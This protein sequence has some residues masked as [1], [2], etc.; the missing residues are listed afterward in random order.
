[1]LWIVCWYNPFVWLMRK[2]V[3]QNIEFLTDQQVL[4]RGV[5]RQTYQYSLLNVTQQGTVVGIGNQFNFKTLKKRIMM[6]NK[7]RSSKL[8]LSKYA[9][10][11]PI[12]ILVGATFTVNKAE[13]KIE[14]AVSMVEKTDLAQL[15]SK[16]ATETTD[17]Q[18]TT[19]PTTE[20]VSL[21]QEQDTVRPLKS[22][23]EINQNKDYIYEYDKK[24][25][26]KAQFFAFPDN[27]VYDILLIEDKQALSVW[28]PDEDNMHGIV[29]AR[30]LEGHEK[31]KEIS[32]KILIVID[33]EIKENTSLSELDPNKIESMN[34]LKDQSSTAK[35]GEKGKDGVIEITTKGE[36]KAIVD[37]LKGKA[38]GLRIRGISTQSGLN[39]PFFI[40]DGKEMPT[41]FDRQS[42][43]PDQIESITVL[44]DDDAKA[45]YGDKGK[46]GVILIKTKSKDSQT[47]VWKN[48]E[49]IA[50]VT[51][52]GYRRTDSNNEVINENLDSH[53]QPEGGMQN[54]R[55]WVANNFQYPIDAI[56]AGIKGTLIMTFVV[57]ADG[58]LSDIK[59]IND[60]GHNIGQSAAN[61]LKRSPKWEPGTKDGKQVNVRYT[62]P[63]KLDLSTFESSKTE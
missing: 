31:A 60:L 42:L 9:F 10:L 46:E 17:T 49:E 28:Y 2:A 62:F 1:M 25:I 48:T 34:V 54:F 13:G 57:R 16:Q 43:D 51:I 5:D 20:E 47:S 32:K 29:R 58:S 50:P 19:I 63:I 36:T 35:Y 33:G 52:I 38:V 4:N 7:K 39:K 18:N 6:M 61:L 37:T 22:R 40:V 59:A 41:D 12:L 27:E 23:A 56:N 14:K 26:S 44:K 21:K 8:E 24:R 15:V 3:R 30:S 55:Q 11:L 53:P 45:V